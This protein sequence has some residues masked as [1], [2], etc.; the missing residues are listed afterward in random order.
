[1]HWVGD[2][3]AERELFER[4]RSKLRRMV[5][6]RM[7][8]RLVAR[9]DPSDVVQE[10]LLTASAGGA[11][12]GWSGVQFG[13]DKNGDLNRDLYVSNNETDEV[14]VFDGDDG[15]PLGVF[16]T[17]GRGGIDGP[18]YMQFGPYGNLYFASSVNTTN[19]DQVEQ[20]YRYD[21]T[22]GAFIDI[23]VAVGSGLSGA[24]TFLTF[25]LQGDLLVSGQ[26]AGE[27]LRYSAGP[28]VSLSEAS[29][30]PVTIDF[31]TSAQTALPGSDYK[32]VTG[33][34]TFA[35]G[36]TSKAD[37]ELTDSLHAERSRALSPTNATG[38]VP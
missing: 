24:T 4:H 12:I 1:M 6:I 34:L 10:A 11:S 26:G 31:S 20:V 5:S 38:L 37:E 19:F 13:P 17:A 29:A 32:A 30:S 28:L 27:V 36:E 14:L 33:R 16:V 22:T 23:P 35:S 25:N 7:D 9:F 8:P 15:S 3:L 2:Q 18:Q 21:R